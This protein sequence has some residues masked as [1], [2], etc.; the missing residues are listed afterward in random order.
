MKGRNK[1]VRLLISLLF[2]IVYGL[3]LLVFLALLS[4]GL[5]WLLKD[6]EDPTMFILTF[7]FAMFIL[8]I[9]QHFNHKPK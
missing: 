5:I 2:G 1:F 6:F 7:L 4:F 9:F 8:L 3:A